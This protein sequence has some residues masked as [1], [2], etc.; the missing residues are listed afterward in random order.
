VCRAD[1][2]I[3]DCLEILRASNSRSPKRVF[4]LVMGRLYLLVSSQKIRVCVCVC[5]CVCVFVFVCVCARARF[6][7]KDERLSFGDGNI[8]HCLSLEGHIK[9]LSLYALCL[10][11]LSRLTCVYIRSKT[12]LMVRTSQRI[13]FIFITKIN[14]LVLLSDIIGNYM[15]LVQDM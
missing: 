3:A 13:Q 10:L 4:R 6:V 8:A 7:F 11:T 5:V 2:T 15:G 12:T 1:L 9:I 14:K